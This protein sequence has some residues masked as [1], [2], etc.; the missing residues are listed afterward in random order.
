M[1]APGAPPRVSA[2][3]REG[4]RG[5]RTGLRSLVAPRDGAAK[6]MAGFRGQF[7]PEPGSAALPGVA[8]LPP[9]SC[10][11]CSVLTGPH[12]GPGCCHPHTRLGL[13]SADSVPRRKAAWEEAALRL[14]VWRL[15]RT[16]QLLRAA[17]GGIRGPGGPAS[18]RQH[19]LSGP[20]CSDCFLFLWP[21]PAV[22][23]SPH[24]A[25]LRSPQQAVLRS[26]RQAVLRSPQQAV[27][28]SPR[29][30]VLTL[31]CS[32]DHRRAGT[33][34]RTG[35]VQGAEGPVPSLGA[36]SGPGK[37]K[38]A[39]GPWPGWCRGWRHGQAERHSSSGASRP[40]PAGPVP[41][42]PVLLPPALEG[43]GCGPACL[44]AAVSSAE[45]VHGPQCSHAPSGKDRPGWPFSAPPGTPLVSSAQ[46][47]GGAATWTREQTPVR[48][49]APG[50]GFEPE[51][52]PALAASVCCSCVWFLDPGSV[53]PA[54]HPAGSE[55]SGKARP[56]AQPLTDRPRG[57]GP[58]PADSGR[59]LRLRPLLPRRI[60]SIWGGAT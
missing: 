43:A 31:D 27:L 19:L 45:W 59:E 50:L 55:C 33:R 23:R 46:T 36:T 38:G 48:S 30:A 2:R 57:A 47:W 41:G 35:S 53:A 5:P 12:R 14:V 15:G 4:G 42:R 21:H 20:S 25:V 18:C 37:K 13:D 22:L 51:S 10:P 29:Q 17:P 7:A 49:P 54:P 32:R 60:A 6:G 34:T 11:P 56:G 39:L 1:L 8:L 26:P 52:V 40:H 24:Q 16:R 44:P 58:E 9:P 28:R 3:P